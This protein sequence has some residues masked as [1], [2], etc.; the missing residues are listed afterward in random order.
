MSKSIVGSLRFALLGTLRAW[1]ANLPVDLGPARQRAVLVVLL[2]RRGQAVS[3][4]K[5]I[6][7]V[8]GT[9]PPD[10]ATS[11]V[12]TYV[13]GLRETLEPDRIRYGRP[14]FLV[15][16]S[17]SYR[18]PIDARELDTEEFERVVG[19][20]R[21][22][23]ETGNLAEA[24]ILFAT[25]LELSDGVPLSCLDSSYIRS[26]RHRLLEQQ[27]SARE[28]R[29][30]IELGLGRH[31]E[32]VPELQNIV[33]E[34]PLEE[35]LHALL[36]LALYRSGRTSEALNAFQAARRTLRD[37]LGT[38]PGAELRR[39]HEQILR[40]DPTLDCLA[41]AQTA[42]Q[43][44]AT[45][46]APSQLPP[47]P[48]PFT[49]RAKELDELT[50][51]LSTPAERG[52][53]VVITALAGAG[54]LG[55]TWLVLHWANRHL[56][57]FPDGNLFVDLRGFS[58]DGP[59]LSPIPVLRGFLEGLGVSPQDLPDDLHELTVR[60]RRLV[61]GKRMLIVLDNAADTTQVT[62]LLPD[63][64]MA[65]VLVT[66]RNHLPGLITGHGASHLRVDALTDAE[67][68]ALLVTRLG[69]ERVRR[70]PEA[71][72]RLLDGCGGFP[73]ALGI[74]TSR[75]ETHQHLR[76][77]TL[78]AEL[79]EA[80]LSALDSD[81]PAASL[82]AVLQ[83][84]RRAL[85]PEQA[86]VFE[87]LG[88]APGPDLGLRAAAS[89]ANLTVNQVRVILRSLEQV[90]LVESDAHGRYRMH[91]LIRQSAA[92]HAARNQSD[93][94]EESALRR[95]ADFYLHSANVGDW[96]LDPY[97]SPI[98]LDL[99]APGCARQ[100]LAE[101]GAAMAWFEAEHSCLLAVQ[102]MAA[103]RGWHMTVL[104]L[105]WRMRTFQQ[106]RGLHR[107]QVRTWMAA[108]AATEHLREP[109][110]RTLAHLLL[111]DAC[112]RAGSH[113][114]ALDHIGRGLAVAEQT[115]KVTDQ[116][117]AHRAFA[118]AWEQRGDDRRALGHITRAL[119]LYRVVGNEVREADAL[120]LVGWY[121]A[122]GGQYDE[123]LASCE[124]ALV[125]HR[126]H[127]NL[128]GEAGCMDSFGYIAHHCGRH[129]E[130]VEYYEQA[131]A[132]RREIHHT[133]GEANTL[134]HLGYPLLAL[135]KKDRARTVWR[136]ARALC[137]I[138]QRTVEE[139]RI[140]RT[141][142]GLS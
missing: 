129:R 35:K 97:S 43:K 90:S 116:A 104:Q 33:V 42:Q 128:N 13:R 88:L 77:A 55:K 105:A 18:I 106:R 41:I 59:P 121:T 79:G 36:M 107:D 100:P 141:L 28:E 73:L 24:S 133:F 29:I 27:L 112:V 95:L 130:A 132:L 40:E 67:A 51:A 5:I 91:D 92:E 74:V 48:R 139:Q 53:T 134:E 69:T 7:A 34:H 31:R 61:A 98:Q 113:D 119:E 94:E 52:G 93:V 138:Q 11:L 117:H 78:A 103:A 86:R 99:P 118:R 10:S 68:R 37:D 140:Q 135:G 54:G 114:E 44:S 108:L 16:G 57:L 84:S 62:G 110:T 120:N 12:R 125:L 142:D 89:L 102:H 96:L 26:I 131:L 15:S 3:V 75:A 47:A 9:T 56:N 17:G 126:R 32:I 76:L 1:R 30:E 123:A 22:A 21:N 101:P 82:P 80:G 25:A 71:V 4:D 19:Q 46:T 122:R 58:P 136:E 20:A 6:D 115:G 65:T 39:I 111:G 127:H 70:E 64:P 87:L 14:S 81:D 45:A 124:N 38:H 85:T 109:T 66:S 50:H 8:W 63:S 60:Y 49:G 72:D 83:C 137:Q 2:L 23:R